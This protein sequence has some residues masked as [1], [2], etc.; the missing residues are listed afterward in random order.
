[1]G[2]SPDQE[3]KIPHASGQLRLH[4]HKQITREP[5]LL[6]PW[7]LEPMLH[8][9]R[10]PRATIKNTHARQPETLLPLTATR[11]SLWPTM[12]SRHKIL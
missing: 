12:E 3:T 2:S 1:M 8:N 6:S 10:S 11:E 4:N 5:Q 7:T 9:Q